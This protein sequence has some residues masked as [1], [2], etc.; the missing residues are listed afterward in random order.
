MKKLLSIVMVLSFMLALL[1]ATVFAADQGELVYPL[2]AGKDGE[3]IGTVSVFND[4]DFLTVE[5]KIDGSLTPDDNYNLLKTQVLADTK[6]PLKGALATGAPGQ[7]PFEHFPVD[8]SKFDSFKI[9]LEDIGQTGANVDDTI[10]VAFH[11][12]VENFNNIIGY[13]DIDGVV[14][15]ESGSDIVGYTAK[16]GFHAEP[17][18]DVVCPTLDDIA[19]ALPESLTATVNYSN[20]LFTFDISGGAL[21]G[22]Y[23]GY[24]IDDGHYIYPVGYG[25]TGEYTMNVFSSYEELPDSITSV[26]EQPW[27]APIGGQT[28]E[29]GV[30]ANIDNPDNLDLV[31]WV[32]NNREGFDDNEVQRVIWS[33]VD[34]YMD[35][36]LWE[37]DRLTDHEKVLYDEA[38]LQD[39]FVPADGQK[40]AIVLQPVNTTDQT[41]G[42]VTI[43]QVTIGQVTFAALGL[44]CLNVDWTP[45]Y[46]DWTD[47]F[48]GDTSWAITEGDGISFP[49]GNN[50][51]LYYEYEVT[52]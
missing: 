38:L 46:Q 23:P 13:T 8:N 36:I 6:E 1:P 16:D 52:E 50:W 7:F 48:K 28:D 11:A 4:G 32:I 18:F 35:N 39:G 12:N 17:G 24:C 30:N 10:Y 47:V 21:A 27:V 43:G 42:Q 22:T 20:G 5:F 37:Y 15:A 3:Q 31:N 44:E 51:G 26:Y 2:Q 14:H 49:R 41:T 25:G 45:V 19:A 9:S 34:D 40:L 29:Q 33:L